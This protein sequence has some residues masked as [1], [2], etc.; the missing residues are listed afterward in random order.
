MRYLV[1]L[2]PLEPYFLGGERTFDFGETKQQVRSKYFIKSEELPS[3]TTLLGVMRYYLLENAELLSNEYESDEKSE[4][5]KLIGPDSFDINIEEEQSFGVINKISPLFLLNDQ[6]QVL[7]PTPFNHCV[8][9]EE[10]V[11]K[12][13]KKYMEFEKK[14]EEN[15]GKKILFSDFDAKEGITNSFLELSSHNIPNKG[16]KRKTPKKDLTTL[17]IIKKEPAKPD[18]P[19]IF[20]KI[21]KVGIRKNNDDQNK[22]EEGFFK[23]EYIILNED[24]IFSFFVDLN[25]DDLALENTIVYLG[26]NKSAFKLSITKSNANGENESILRIKSQS[27]LEDKNSNNKGYSIYYALSDTLMTSEN[28]EKLCAFSI[29]KT[30]FFR[31]LKTILFKNEDNKMDIKKNKHLFNLVS[32]GSVFYVHAEK[33]KEF[34]T[35]LE[36][37]SSNCKKIGLNQ[38]IKIGGLSE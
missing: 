20:K 38:I 4:I 25:K 7:V 29:I 31:G 30:K 28:Y 34:K 23:K 8:K 37:L 16:K 1:K 10:G 14:I 36:K 24:Y 18:E 12:P 9:D 17:K 26:Q 35:C 15:T 21:T 33:E 6:K 13:F 11:Y 2:K 19:S 22:K 3:Q 5:E 27:L 32:A